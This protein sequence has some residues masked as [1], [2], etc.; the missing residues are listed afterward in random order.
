[1]GVRVPLWSWACVAV[2]ALS[3]AAAEPARHNEA[4]GG[5]SYVAPEGWTIKEFPGLKFKMV[6]GPAADGFAPQV[7][8]ADE[9]H[10]G[11]LDAFAT[12][13][14]EMLAKAF[15]NF[16]LLKEEKLQS[17]KNN[18]VKLVA[19]CTQQGKSVR[20]TFYLCENGADK[21]VVTCTALAADAVKHEPAFDALFKTLQLKAKE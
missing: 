8:F 10:Q 5:F 12:A 9:S 6:A 16:K 15:E 20:Q 21:L 19:E 13:S 4:A 3:A 7:I 18:V 1:M 2:L 11:T 17:G 14:K